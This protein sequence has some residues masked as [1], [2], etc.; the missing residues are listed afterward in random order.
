MT[1]AFLWAFFVHYNSNKFRIKYTKNAQRNA[2]HPAEPL[3]QGHNTNKIT[4]QSR[5]LN[6]FFYLFY[7][8]RNPTNIHEKGTK[9]IQTSV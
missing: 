5:T 9:D 2:F 8:A 7:V 6:I 4:I 3:W 1:R